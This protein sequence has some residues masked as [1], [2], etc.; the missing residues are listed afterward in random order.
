MCVLSVDEFVNEMI[1]YIALEDLLD[2]FCIR[3]SD[4][5]LANVHAGYYGY[6]SQFWALRKSSAVCVS[7]VRNVV[8]ER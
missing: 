8:V 4:E 5:S 7:V 3:H 1:Q 2:K 6:Y